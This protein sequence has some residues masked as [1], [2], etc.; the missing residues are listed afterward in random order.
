MVAHEQDL[1]PLPRPAYPRNQNLDSKNT[2]AEP[3]KQPRDQINTITASEKDD[4]ALDGHEKK[5]Y[6]PIGAKPQR[7]TQGGKH[8]QALS[9]AEGASANRLPGAGIAFPVARS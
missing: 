2:N 4:D 6:P 5:T 3:V 1:P 7:T 8:G 9:C